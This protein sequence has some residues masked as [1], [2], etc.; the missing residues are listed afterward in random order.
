[1]PLGR[2]HYNT[3]VVQT[4]KQF[5]KKYYVNTVQKPSFKIPD[6][7]GAHTEFMREWY[8]GNIICSN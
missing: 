6:K 7:N 2:H 4:I 1:M 8:L 3:G 5:S